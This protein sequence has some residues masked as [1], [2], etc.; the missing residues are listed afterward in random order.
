MLAS[1]LLVPFVPFVPFVPGEVTGR[2]S[3]ELCEAGEGT[4]L[5][6]QEEGW[7]PARALGPGAGSRWPATQLAFLK[8]PLW[9]RRHRFLDV[10][11]TCLN[12]QVPF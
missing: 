9:L 10:A 1:G 4:P 7:T 12:L 8:L 6:R 5:P 2:L 3:G 11:W